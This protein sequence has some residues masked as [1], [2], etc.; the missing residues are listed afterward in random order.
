MT[1][2]CVMCYLMILAVKPAVQ[3]SDGRCNRQVFGGA[4]AISLPGL[5]RR[6]PRPL[7]NL[8]HRILVLSAPRSASGYY[9]EGYARSV[10]GAVLY[11]PA[12]PGGEVCTGCRGMLSRT[13]G[14]EGLRPDGLW[15]GCSDSGW[16]AF[17]P[18]GDL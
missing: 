14:E 16:C 6:G 3:G 8:C 15:G 1:K 4:K 12:R 13:R 2:P 17:G 10:M 18:D 7:E 5:V 9:G 11:G